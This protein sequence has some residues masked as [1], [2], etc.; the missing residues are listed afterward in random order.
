M[1]YE[2]IPLSVPGAQAPAALT[3][4]LPDNF[5]DLGPDRRRPALIICP[6]GAYRKL[7][8]REGEPV[9][10]RF[11]GL[12]YAA[13]VLYYHVAP[14]ARYPI[15]QRQLLAAI[16]H[17][18]SHVEEYHVDPAAVI[19]L[20]FSAGGHLAGCAAL[21]WNRSGDRAPPGEEGGGLPARRGGAVLPGGVRR[22]PRP[23][24]V[25]P[26][27]PGRAVSE[28]GPLPLPGEP[29][30]KGGAP[31]LP[32]AHRRRHHGPHGEHPPAGDGP[33]GPGR[34]GGDPHLPPRRPRPVPGGPHRL[35]PGPSV[36]DLRAL[37]RLGG[38]LPRLAPAEFQR[39][40]G[41]GG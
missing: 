18:R 37:R 40:V 8:N 12:G 22:G 5:P 29:G 23:P 31:F 34:A 3:A 14:Q 16:D 39:P 15:P 33:P 38:A 41:G 13:F 26:K 28:E 11:A 21:L 24:R 1:R 35:P 17:V 32:L 7:S 20:G 27:P 6:G 19:P 10:L 25:P 30:E 4:Y 2:T 9:A 36:A